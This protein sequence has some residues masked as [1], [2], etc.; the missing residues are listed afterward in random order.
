MQWE[1]AYYQLWSFR[2]SW[3]I[4]AFLSRR[5]LEE[6]YQ[7]VFEETVQPDPKK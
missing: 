7:P 2:L 1:A 5:A 4:R 6:I 3:G